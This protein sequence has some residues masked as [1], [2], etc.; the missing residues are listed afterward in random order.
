VAV[1]QTLPGHLESASGT[2]RMGK[3]GLGL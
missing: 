1:L 2:S 3:C